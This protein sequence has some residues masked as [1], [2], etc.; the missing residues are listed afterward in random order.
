MR[1]RENQQCQKA[2]PRRREYSFGGLHMVSLLHL[3]LHNSVP[4]KMKMSCVEPM[5]GPILI[6]GNKRKRKA[7][8]IYR[9]SNPHPL[10]SF[11]GWAVLKPL[12]DLR[13]ELKH[14]K[15]DRSLVSVTPVKG[16]MLSPIVMQQCSRRCWTPFKALFIL[17]LITAG[18]S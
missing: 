13:I 9:E 16:I 10:E 11:K 7:P 12:P 5:K 8:G 2:C 4:F 3:K 1:R 17:F 6:T 14:F 18:K 15:R